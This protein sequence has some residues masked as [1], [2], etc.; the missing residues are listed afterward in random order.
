[1]QTNNTEEKQEYTREE[2]IQLFYFIASGFGLIYWVVFLVIHPY[3]HFS[4]KL[5]YM[6]IP[7]SIVGLALLM[8]SRDAFRAEH[9]GLSFHFYAGLLIAGSL[10]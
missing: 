5:L 7:Y 9:Y 1:M 6:T 2:L 8:V 10:A 4:G 3:A